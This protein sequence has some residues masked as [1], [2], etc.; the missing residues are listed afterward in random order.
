MSEYYTEPLLPYDTYFFS[1]WC[2]I[3]GIDADKFK[4]ISN[5]WHTSF[6]IARL[7]SEEVSRELQLREDIEANLPLEESVRV[8]DLGLKPEYWG[9][10]PKIFQAPEGLAYELTL[11]VAYDEFDEYED[12]TPAPPT[13]IE[14]KRFVGEYLDIDVETE[15]G[16]QKGYVTVRERPDY[17]ALPILNDGNPDENGAIRLPSRYNPD[18]DGAYVSFPRLDGWQVAHPRIK[19]LGGRHERTS[20]RLVPFENP[21]D[22][23]LFVADFGKYNDFKLDDFIFQDEERLKLPPGF[24]YIRTGIDKWELQYLPINNLILPPIPRDDWT[25]L[26]NNHGIMIKLNPT[27]HSFAFGD[28]RFQYLDFDGR[29]SSL[30]FAIRQF[31]SKAEKGQFIMR[32]LAVQGLHGTASL[33]D[34][35][36]VA[37]SKE[38]L[39]EK[40]ER[41][42]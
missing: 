10:R 24:C 42:T 15:R 11:E 17:F 16:T 23:E 39:S 9:M 19:E 38:L 37:L 7:R 28:S 5:L 31:N 27:V 25:P 22:T 26:W 20:V 34:V 8:D 18:E 6:L 21:Q 1:D 32:A 35:L 3:K 4:N 29:R 33:S 30:E 36:E 12:G 14:Y 41:F 13:K 2:D 40:D